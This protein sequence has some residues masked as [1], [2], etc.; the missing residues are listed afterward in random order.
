MRPL[1]GRNRPFLSC[2]I[3]FRFDVRLLRR[4]VAMA[5]ETAEHAYAW[6]DEHAI[7]GEPYLLAAIGEDGSETPIDV[8][9]WQLPHHQA[10]LR[11]A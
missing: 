7:A 3:V 1:P 11:G 8:G 10:R 2:P 4:Q 9:L 6:L 5:V